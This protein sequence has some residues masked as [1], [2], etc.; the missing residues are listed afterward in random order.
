ME[1]DDIIS[2]HD[3]VTAEKIVLQKGMNYGVGKNHSVFLMSLRD[4]APYAGAHDRYTNIEVNYLLQCM[5]KH[6]SVMI[7]AFQD[8]LSASMTG[9]KMRRVFVKVPPK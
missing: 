9:K 1:V 2:Y 7:A 6:P 5:D 3:V 4:N 8:A